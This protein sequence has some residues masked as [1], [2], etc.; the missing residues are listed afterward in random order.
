MPHPPEPPT[1]A[2]F[3]PL[4][5]A[6]IPELLLKPHAGMLPGV[7]VWNQRPFFVPLHTPLVPWC[8]WQLGSLL[9]GPRFGPG[10]SPAFDASSSVSLTGSFSF[11][12]F[13]KRHPRF[14]P[15]L[16]HSALNPTHKW[17]PSSHVQTKPSPKFQTWF[18]LETENSA[19]FFFTTD[20]KAFFF[21]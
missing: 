17:L 20:Y 1:A 11:T 12:I 13:F 19:F 9:P 6:P 21:F 5:L 4:L 10:S 2:Q 8:S 15:W 7:C 18:S 16:S 14:H 3:S